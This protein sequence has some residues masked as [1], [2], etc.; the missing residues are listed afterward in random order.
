MSRGLFETAFNISV[1]RHATVAALDE[2]QH[3]QMTTLS[4]DEVSDVR[5][6]A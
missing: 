3:F 2:L 6:D 4:Q 5:L 1:T